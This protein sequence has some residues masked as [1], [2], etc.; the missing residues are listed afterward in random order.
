MVPGELRGITSVFCVFVLGIL[1][2]AE[3]WLTRWLRFFP[4]L[5][6]IAIILGSAAHGMFRVRYNVSESQLV[7]AAAS[8]KAEHANTGGSALTDA[9]VKQRAVAATGV[10]VEDRT[11]TDYYIGSIR[12]RLHRGPLR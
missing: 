5:A 3:G 1:A 2:T 12:C 4:M 8:I 9:E 10:S 7:A 11:M 6:L